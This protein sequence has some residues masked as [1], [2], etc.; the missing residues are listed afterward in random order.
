MKSATILKAAHWSM[1]TTFILSLAIL[2]IIY[3]TELNLS[4]PILIVLHILVVLFAA[5]FKISYVARLTV[6]T[7]LGRPVH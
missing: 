1:A 2:Y 5:I 4:I 3:G 7:Q 6:L